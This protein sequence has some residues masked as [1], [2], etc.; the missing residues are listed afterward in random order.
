MSLFSLQ[1]E[2]S[3]Q[4]RRS[5]KDGR[6]GAD[7]HAYGKKEGEMLGGGGTEDVESNEGDENGN[8]GVDRAGEGLGN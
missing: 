3:N 6:V 7:D 4:Q 2:E 1:A 5:D 8:G